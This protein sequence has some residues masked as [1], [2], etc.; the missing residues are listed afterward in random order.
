[1]IGCD[2]EQLSQEQV[3]SV[4]TVVGKLKE[5]HLHALNEYYVP[6]TLGNHL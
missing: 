6:T 3:S 5:V 4:I 1:M 2:A